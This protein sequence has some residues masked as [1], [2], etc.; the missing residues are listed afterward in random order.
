MKYIYGLNK[1]GQSIIKFLN[2][3]NEPYCCWDENDKIRKKL[4][5]EN[6]TINLVEPDSLNFKLINESFVT[7]G[8]SLSD[9]KIEKLRNNKISLYRDLELYSRI[10]KNKKIIAITGTNGKSTTAK[11]ISDL[12][13]RNQVSNFLGGNIGIPLLDFIHNSEKIKHHVIELS[14]FQLE[15]VNSF[16]PYISILLNIA[17]DHLDR[18]N[19]YSEYVLQ[20]EK[21]ISLNKKGFNILCID[22]QKTKEL[23]KKYKEKIIPISKKYVSGG[24]YIK[25]NFII[26]NY[27]KENKKIN[28]NSLSSS[29]FGSFNIE[30]ILSAYVVARILEIDINSFLSLLKQFK[31]LPHRLEMIHKN[32]NLQVINNSKATNLHASLQSISNYKNIYLILGGKAKEKDFNEVLDFKD[33]IYKIYLIGESAQ[34]IFKQLS[35]KIKCEICVTIEIAVKKILLDIKKNREFKTILF[36]PACTSFDQFKNFETRGKFFKKTIK[37]LIYE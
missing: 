7:P 37:N 31:G 35:K 28:I 6:S 1:S 29:L 32:D 12:L 21:I 18:Y 26:D 11:L 34:L 2:K 8:V 19:S 33:N 25:N 22:D 13:N 16:D 36:S 17:P 4:I 23:Y 15:S 9:H 5:K 20:K 3:I 10:A 30:N 14:S 24:I 27:F